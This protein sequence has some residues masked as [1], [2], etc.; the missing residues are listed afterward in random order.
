MNRADLR[1]TMAELTCLPVRGR[2]LNI[3]KEVPLHKSE[4][5]GMGLLSDGNI[6]GDIIGRCGDNL[7]R[8]NTEVLQAW[9][10]GKG[11][12]VTWRYLWTILSTIGCLDLSRLIRHNITLEYMYI[13]L[14]H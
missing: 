1:P 14:L 13:R 7:M 9:L 3:P 11:E 5:F 8:A 10:D 4:L 12:N 2:I 6:V